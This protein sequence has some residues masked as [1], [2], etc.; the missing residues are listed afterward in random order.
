[1]DIPITTFQN[2]SINSWDG[3]RDILTTAK[4]LFVLTDQNVEQDCRTIFEAQLPNLAV[5]WMVIPAGES[6]KSLSQCDQIWS[7]LLENQIGTDYL[8]VNLGGGVVSD[9]GGFCAAS[10]KRGMRIVNIPT[11]L[12]GMVDA[13]I[14]G[15]NGINHHF[16]KNC[17]GTLKLPE[18]I[19]VETKFLKSLPQIEI[20]QGKAEM[21]KYGLIK[22]IALWNQLTNLSHFEVPDLSSIAKSIQ[23]KSEIVAVD[24]YEKDVRRLLNFGH[25]IAHGLEGIAQ[26]NYVPLTHGDA[27]FIGML[28]ESKISQLKGNLP[29][30]EYETIENVFMPIIKNINY[31]PD[32]FSSLW[33]FIAND[34]KKRGSSIK[35]S[36]LSSIGTSSVEIE[37]TQTLINEAILQTKLSRN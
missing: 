15:K 36:S 30:S 21:F 24:L 31:N 23:I 33:T 14:G 10:Y 11:S 1:M 25:T 6:S 3:F 7:Q 32:W 19:V 12:L 29:A 20:L 16:V 2:I 5:L 34:K 9:I 28:V 35:I 8:W 13:S 27:V 4:G 22:D 18:L 37:L 17:I 26:E